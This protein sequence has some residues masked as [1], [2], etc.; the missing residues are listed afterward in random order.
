MYIEYHIV[1]CTEAGWCQK[2]ILSGGRHL[3]TI[4]RSPLQLSCGRNII[5]ASYMK[6]KR[7]DIII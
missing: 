1:I 5:T 6:Q 4:W 2:N 7:V 3:S